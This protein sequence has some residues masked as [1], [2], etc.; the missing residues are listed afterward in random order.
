[1]CGIAGVIHKEGLDYYTNIE[2]MNL[3]QK[4]RGPDDSGIVKLNGAIFGH[5]RLSIVDI[6]FGHQPMTCNDKNISITFNGEIYGYKDLK[7]TLDYSFTTQSDTEVILAL[8]KKYGNEMFSKLK[9]M[10]AF[11]I[12]N[13]KNK[14]LLLGRDRFGE[15]PLYYAFGRNGELIFASEIK[16]IIASNLVKPRVSKKVLGH[17]LQY[18][19]IDPL[20]T[21][22]ENIHTVEPGCFLELTNGEVN[23]QRYY[24]YPTT[25]NISI[26][27]AADMFKDKFETSVENQ[28]IADV[29]VGAFLSGG[30][31]SSTIV[32]VAK[33]YKTDLKTFSF[34]FEGSKSELPYAR[35][36]AIKYNTD[37]YELFA[38]DL[39]VSQMLLK[40]TEVY[41]EPF[42]DSSNIPTYL[43]SKLAREH[44]KVILTGDGADE[45]LG[46]YGWWYDPLLGVGKPVNYLKEMTIRV[47]AKSFFKSY[48]SKANRM[49]S[50]R[51]YD[52][53]MNAHINRHSNFN[54][55]EVG[56]LLGIN[57]DK[58]R[59]FKFEEENTINDALKIDLQEYMAGDILVKTDRASMANSLELRSPFLD[60][61]F[62]S[63]CISLPASLKITNKEDKYILRQTYQNMWTK[64]IRSRN[65]QGFGAPIGQWLKQ[66]SMVALK[67]E[68]FK[69]N[70][71]IFS[72]VSFDVAKKYFFKDN[73]QTWILLVLSIWFDKN[74][75]NIE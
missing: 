37:H 61:D 6:N 54:N 46:G 51:R 44:S 53:V 11:G 65:K 39:D 7:D 69:K 21:I 52:S 56:D 49:R 63:F 16:A 55:Y 50:G 2:Q 3:V 62:A 74:S 57:Y 33:K 38:K 67:D 73:Y 19:Y 47:L 23:I 5:T 32:A 41:D 35:E 31:D 42:A 30:L 8:Y 22:Y 14:S 58:D 1:M 70:Q 36:L 71:S 25:Q 28:L 20:E 59:S 43:I 60:V 13:A 18:L 17:Y 9:G 34:G 64:S 40:M 48:Q 75:G 72:F 24:N 26:D 4:H 29:D 15:K 45:L 12:W 66:K 10:F 68:Y 27:D